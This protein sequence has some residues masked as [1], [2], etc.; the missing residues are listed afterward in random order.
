MRTRETLVEIEV[1][2]RALSKAA[3]PVLTSGSGSASLLI[4][5]AESGMRFAV[6]LQV[7][8]AEDA[9]GRLLV[10]AAP[11]SAAAHH[12]VAFTR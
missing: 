7:D 11:G 3:H 4:G 9:S 1:R 12:A 10:F 8:L 5:A 2:R 6:R